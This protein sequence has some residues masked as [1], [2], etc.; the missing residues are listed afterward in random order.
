MIHTRQVKVNKDGTTPLV[1][2]KYQTAVFGASGSQ[3]R[4]ASHHGS[5]ATQEVHSQK[6]ESKI[7]AT[8]DI[9]SEATSTIGDHECGIKLHLFDPGL[10]ESM[11]GKEGVGSVDLSTI[12]QAHYRNC[13]GIIICFDLSDKFSFINVEKWISEAKES[14]NENCKFILVGTKADLPS[15]NPNN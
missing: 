12:I 10:P 8:Q 11:S 1:D 4:I 13:H 6:E 15:N 14:V 9:K 7:T 3:G 5:E 2:P